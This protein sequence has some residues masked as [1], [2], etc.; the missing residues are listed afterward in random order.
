MA[1][2]VYWVS[3]EKKERNKEYERERE[4]KRKESRKWEENNEGKKIEEKK[5]ES[6]E[7]MELHEKDLQDIRDTIKALMQGELKTLREGVLEFRDSK[8]I[9]EES[10]HESAGGQEQR[11]KG[12]QKWNGQIRGDSKE[13]SE[14]NRHESPGR[15]DQRYDKNVE[16]TQ[17]TGRKDDSAIVQ[18]LET[19]MLNQRE[20]EWPGDKGNDLQGRHKVFNQDYASSNEYF[21]RNKLVNKT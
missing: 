13:E 8:E 7:I 19:K 4:R 10:R 6:I 15:Q 11:Y 14:E 20:G 1:K 5:K 9:T 2:Q 18:Q 17:Q 21:L 16:M 12:F 3:R